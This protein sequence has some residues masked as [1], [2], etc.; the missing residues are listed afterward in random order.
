MKQVYLARHGQTDYNKER[1]MQGRGIDSPLNS[2]GWQQ[3][4]AIASYLSDKNVTQIISSSLTRAIESA[5]P[6]A[7]QSSLTVKSFADL[8]EMD[9]GEL[10]GKLI[11]EVKEEL[12]YLQEQWSSS[13][14]LVKCPGGENPVQVFE[15]ANKAIQE[16]LNESEHEVILF[17]LHGR[18]LRILLSNWLGM[19]LKNMHKIDHENGAINHLEWESGTFKVS[20]LN[21][22]DHLKELI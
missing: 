17:V 21:K 14:V 1:R 19:G 10:E 6:M 2:L 12:Q 15:R 20:E 11:F 7:N 22:T 16:I 18:L 3:A 13:D 4:E 8:D 9:F 5:T